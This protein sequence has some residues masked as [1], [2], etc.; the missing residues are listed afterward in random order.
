MNDKER[1]EAYLKRCERQRPKLLGSKAK[2]ELYCVGTNEKI[3][4]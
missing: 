1:L 3:T 4:K 2:I